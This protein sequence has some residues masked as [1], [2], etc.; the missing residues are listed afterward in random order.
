MFGGG[1]RV[2]GGRGRDRETA[3]QANR[4]TDNKT[5]DVLLVEFMYLVLLV[6]YATG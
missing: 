6:D 2:G 4:Q 3:R 1:M 5:E